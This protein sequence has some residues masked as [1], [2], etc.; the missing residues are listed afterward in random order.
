MP[1][2]PRIAVVDYGY[3]NL[4]SV[5]KALEACALRVDVTGDPV[6]LARF[7]TDTGETTLVLVIQ[8]PVQNP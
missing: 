7:Q 2:P 5:A 6:D 1:T 8:V 3:G 4:R